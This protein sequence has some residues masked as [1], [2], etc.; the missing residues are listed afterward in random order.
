MALRASWMW[1]AAKMSPRDVDRSGWTND[2]GVAEVGHGGVDHDVTEWAGS[3]GP[4]IT[5]GTRLKSPHPPRVRSRKTRPR[6][7]DTLVRSEAKIISVGSRDSPG[8][9]GAGA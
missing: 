8:C 4:A 5:E 3:V 9:K 1:L 2:G 7:S 6:S